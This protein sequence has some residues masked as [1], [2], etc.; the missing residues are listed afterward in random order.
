[1]LREFAQFLRQNV[2]AWDSVFRYKHG[3][4]FAVI[5]TNTDGAGAR[6]LVERLRGQVALY[7]FQVAPSQVSRLTCS[8]GISVLAAGETTASGLIARAERGLALAKAS[9]NR[10]ELVDGPARPDAAVAPTQPWTPSAPR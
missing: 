5:A 10:V 2:R 4:E 9:K 8:A 6:A 3:D 1:V 7:E